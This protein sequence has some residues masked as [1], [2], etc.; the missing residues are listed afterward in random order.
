MS[1][2]LMLRKLEARVGSEGGSRVTVGLSS[3]GPPPAADRHPSVRERDDR[4]LALE[5]RL[6]AK[7]L[8]VEAA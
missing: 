2:T 7:D 1:A 4:E 5:H 3:V 6:A 8:G